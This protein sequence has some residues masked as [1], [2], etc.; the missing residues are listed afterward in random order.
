MSSNKMKERLAALAEVHFGTRFDESEIEIRPRKVGS[1]YYFDDMRLVM[2][3]CIKGYGDCRRRAYY[4]DGE[5]EPD[6]VILS[7]GQTFADAVH[8]IYPQIG[9]VN[10]IIDRD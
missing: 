4:S 10:V 3:T 2:I 7:T 6:D 9:P 1:V 8:K 5:Y